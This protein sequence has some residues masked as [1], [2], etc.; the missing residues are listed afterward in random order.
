MSRGK[1]KP[2]RSHPR[3]KVSTWLLEQSEICGNRLARLLYR[4]RKQSEVGWQAT[5]SE[6]SAI[7]KKTR[8][9]ATK[10]FKN[11]SKLAPQWAIVGALFFLATVAA[12]DWAAKKHETQSLE[13]PSPTQT[14]SPANGETST[15]PPWSYFHP[16]WKEVD[17]WLLKRVPSDQKLQNSV[18]E[19]RN[20][21]YDPE[22]RVE[23]EFSVPESLR[24]RVVFWMEI[25]SRYN[26]RMRVVHDR[27]NPAILYGFI[28]LRSIYRV[29]GNTVIADVK[30]NEIERKVIKEIKQR[31][32]E[33]VGI[34]PNATVSSDEREQIK[35]FLS[36]VGALSPS[37]TKTLL[38]RI[39]TQTGQSDM[40]LSA[41][42]RARQL[43]PHIESVFRR[44]NLPVGL[45]R[46]PFVESSFNPRAYS[47]GGAIGIWQFMP[48]T[49]RQ[50]IHHE[51]EHWDDPLK[52]TASA[53]RLLRMYR[54]VLPDWGSTVTSYNSGV[55]RVRRLIQKYKIKNIEELLNIDDKDGLGFAGKNFYAEFLAANLVEAYKEELFENAMGSS[56]FSLVFKGNIPFPKDYC[57][58]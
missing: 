52:Q 20:L 12:I 58:L 33:S 17:G 39:R 37:D 56:D 11:S 28:D 16:T 32:Q 42:Y 50:M 9:Q 7:H 4:F 48:E 2:L 10:L 21:V 36:Q 25:Y 26:S 41:L 27:T 49:A 22:N 31:L 3:A 38:T 55:G 34:L 30:A 57:D 23:D 46:I 5:S 51:E 45:G 54:S 19:I 35:A 1:K 47:K 15:N 14:V 40:F 8:K 18:K 6:F 29:Y 43:L 13:S 24:S 44:Q 53:A